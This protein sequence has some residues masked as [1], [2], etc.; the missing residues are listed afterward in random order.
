MRT[1]AVVLLGTILV[2]SLGAAMAYITLG[3][4]EMFGLMLL[5]EE[6]S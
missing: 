2:L 6:E 5:I 4:I 1:V 3:M